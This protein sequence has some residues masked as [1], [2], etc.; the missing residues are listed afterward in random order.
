MLGEHIV[1]VTSIDSARTL[2]RSRL[3]ELISRAE[4]AGC[5]FDQQFKFSER[6]HGQRHRGDVR[7]G[8]AQSEEGMHPTWTQ[9]RCAARSAVTPIVREAQGAAFTGTQA[10]AVGAVISRPGAKVCLNASMHALERKQQR[11]RERERVRE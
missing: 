2:S 9:I 8:D 11:E 1:D 3:R 7:L 4:G 5:S 6:V 10:V